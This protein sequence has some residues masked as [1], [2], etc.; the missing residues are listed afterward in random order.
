MRPTPEVHPASHDDVAS[1]AALI[2][3]ART[4]VSMGVPMD[5]TEGEDALRLHLSVFLAAGGT[6]LVAVLG[7][8]VVG[9]VLARTVG[10]HLFAQSPA[11]IIDLLYVAPDARR[12]GAGRALVGGVASLAAAATAPYVYVGASAGDRGMRRF[13]SRLGFGP[14]AGHRVVATATLQRRLAVQAAGPVSRREGTRAA[15]EE[16][17]ATRRRI[18]EASVQTAAIDL[19]QRG[20]GR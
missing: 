11:W 20:A 7:D 1:V 18:R 17:I 8:R 14:A 13:M 19:R 5:V 2:A 16:V 4:Q 10:P 15:I 9:F 12:H 3:S 6:L